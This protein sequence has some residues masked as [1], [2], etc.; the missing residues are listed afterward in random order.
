VFVGIE[1]FAKEHK[2]P[3]RFDST[4]FPK[5]NRDETPKKFR[6][7]AEKLIELDKL[8]EGRM[9]G[10]KDLYEKTKGSKLSNSLLNCQAGV[11]ALVIDP[12]GNMFIC[13]LYVGFYVLGRD[14]LQ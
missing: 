1:K 11:N 3:F 9:E 2:L 5:L 10:F 12:S 7:P 14:M 13:P 6:L 8:S 4:L